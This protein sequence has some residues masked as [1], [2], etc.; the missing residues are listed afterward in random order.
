MTTKDEKARR[1]NIRR[2]TG[3][4]D[5]PPFHKEKFKW[6]GQ[7]LLAHVCF[8]CR[9]GRKLPPD[10]APHFCHSCNQVMVHMGRSFKIPR[11]SNKRQW[12]KIEILYNQGENFSSYKREHKLPKHLSELNVYFTEKNDKSAPPK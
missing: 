2:K 8:D 12:R 3:S 7:Y 1:M 9:E 10:Y 6:G 4:R 11:K 5:V